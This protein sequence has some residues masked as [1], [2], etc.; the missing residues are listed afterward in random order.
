MGMESF[1]SFLAAQLAQR[2]VNIKKCRNEAKLSFVF[3]EGVVLGIF[4]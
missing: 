1:P 3:N 2:G 4:S